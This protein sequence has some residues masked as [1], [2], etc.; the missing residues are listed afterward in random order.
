MFSAL[1][2]LDIS[3]DAKNRKW[4]IRNVMGGINN[5]MKSGTLLRQVVNKINENISFDEVRGSHL[6]NGLYETMLKDLQS[7]GKAGE[8]YTPRPVTRFIVEK[9]DPKLSDVVLDPACG[10]GGFLT[11]VI[12][13]YSVQTTEEY[14]KLQANIKGI[15]K[16]PF[17]YLLCV[18]N[19]IAHVMI[20]RLID[21]D[22]LDFIHKFLISPYLQN[23]IMNQQV[24][25]SREGLSATKLKNFCIPIPPFSEQQRIAEK[26]NELMMLCDNLEAAEKEL[27][28]I[29]KLF[30]ENLPKSILQAAVQGKLVAQ[31]P[32][33]EPATELLKHIKQEKDELIRGGK[34]KKDK[35]LPPITDDEIPYDLPEGWQWCKMGE[36]CNYGTSEKAEP[37]TIPNDSWLLELEDIEKETGVLQKRITKQNRE[38]K[39]TKNIFSTGQV[40]YGK[41]RPYLNK[42][43]VADDNGYCSSEIL[44]L[45][46]DNIDSYYA[47]TY[48]RSPIFVDYA[49]SKSYGVKMPRLGTDDGKNALFP[50]PPLAEQQRIVSK[51]DEI[52]MLC[53]ELKMADSLPFSQKTSSIIPFPQK[54][55]A[56]VV[57]DRDM[58]IG[59]A[60]RGNAK[61][62]LVGQAALDADELLGE[63]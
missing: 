39:S 38:C 44:P 21:N 10:T 61:G 11:S 17:P 55:V 51:V 4:L 59:I 43:L 20:I 9:V 27:N 36:L 56:S 48:M 24:G 50:L 13:R 47:V 1:R 12:D 60:A 15:E 62:G 58:N 54:A 52:M 14:E 33:D 40:L 29:E 42:I 26:A 8:F 53:N 6:F 41:L 25:A 32:N 34:I 3:E 28:T 5:F 63:E 37:L 46:F 45:S 18:T 35:P 16:K 57:S 30:A 19:L 23:E 7:A 22:L 49:N 31:N 2:N